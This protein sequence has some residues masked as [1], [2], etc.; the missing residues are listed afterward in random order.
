[1]LSTGWTSHT[2]HIDILQEIGLK[3]TIMINKLNNIN[4]SY[5][6]HAMINTSGNYYT[7]LRTIEGRWEGKRGRGIR[8]NKESSGNYRLTWDI[9]WHDTS[10]SRQGC[11]AMN[12]YLFIHGRAMGSYDTTLRQKHI[13]EKSQFTSATILFHAKPSD[14]ATGLPT[15][16]DRPRSHC[17]EQRMNLL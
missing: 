16:A 5:A 12:I 11:G 9:S 14:P 15:A 4:R 3:E 13:Y 6:S 2:T 1:M 8:L 7:L 10:L 17:Y